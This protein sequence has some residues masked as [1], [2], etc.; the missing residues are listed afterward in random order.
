MGIAI[1][2]FGALGDYQRG[3]RRIQPRDRVAFEKLPGEEFSTRSDIRSDARDVGTGTTRANA[4]RPRR[5]RPNAA[6][7]SSTDDG[8]AQAGDGGHEGRHGEDEVFTRA[9]EG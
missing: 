3:N 7:A 6:R 4:S 1:A 9:D 5:W 2:E 8:D